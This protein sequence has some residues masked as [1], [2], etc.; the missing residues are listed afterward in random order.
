MTGPIIDES[1]HESSAGKIAETVEELYNLL[2]DYINK[3]NTISDT[4]I[5][6]KN[7]K[8]AISLY[9]K[10][11]ASI[12][13]AISIIANVHTAASQGFLSDIDDADQ[14]L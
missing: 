7:T 8:N 3:L 1:E 6:Y 9:A 13:Q 4:H 10:Q 14:E 11:A 5:T 12:Q 2:S